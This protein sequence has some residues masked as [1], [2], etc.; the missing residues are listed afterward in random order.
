MPQLKSSEIRHAVVRLAQRL[1]AERPHDGLSTN[2]LAI[3]AHLHRHGATTPTDLAAASR[4][5]PQSLTRL[6]ADLEQA[7]LIQREA[8]QPDRRRVK[9]S[10]TDNG[11][12]ALF[13]NM[14]GRDQW[15]AEAMRTLSETEQEV[16]RI[17]APLLERLAEFPGAPTTPP[18]VDAPEPEAP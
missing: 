6:F 9:L 18:A 3:L 7:A 17:A 11:R 4:Q 15:L 16:L 2:K 12:L 14:A 13:R 10:I 5:L 1:R 8:G